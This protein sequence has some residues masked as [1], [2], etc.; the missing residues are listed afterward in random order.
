MDLADARIRTADPFITSQKPA[1]QAG[2]PQSALGQDM[3]AKSPHC[4]G[5]LETPR[6]AS[7]QADGRSE[8]AG[9]ADSDPHL[10]GRQPKGPGDAAPN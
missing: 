3:P 2:P 7:G 5:L 1:V 8:D 9:D 4:G 6:D 10:A